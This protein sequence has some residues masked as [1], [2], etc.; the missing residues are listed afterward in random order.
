MSSTAYRHTDVADPRQTSVR[1]A[2]SIVTQRDTVMSITAYRQTDIANPR[3]TMD[4]DS[5]VTS[6]VSNPQA[7]HL[8]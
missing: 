7:S 2:P 1:Q 3:P 5:K 4:S 6:T 8:L